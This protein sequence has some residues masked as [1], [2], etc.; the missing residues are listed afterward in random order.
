MQINVVLVKDKLGKI[1]NKSV[2]HVGQDASS[3]IQICGRDCVY[4]LEWKPTGNN[5]Y[6]FLVCKK[7]SDIVNLHKRARERDDGILSVCLERDAPKIPLLF[8]SGKKCKGGFEGVQGFVFCRVDYDPSFGGKLDE[9]GQA[10]RVFAAEGLCKL[11]LHDIHQLSQ[12]LFFDKT[13]CQVSL[14]KK[15]KKRCP[16][17]FCGN[18]KIFVSFSVKISVG[19]VLD[20]AVLVQV[21]PESAKGVV[22]FSHEFFKPFGRQESQIVGAS[23]SSEFSAHG[24][25]HVDAVHVALANVMRVMWPFHA[26]LGRGTSFE[27]QSRRVG[28]KD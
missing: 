13:Q 10:G 20:F 17:F 15:I 25:S 5:F 19:Q 27:M 24:R 23:K 2:K 11:S 14:P 6:K 22:Q 21:N 12:N 28:S 4:E 26:D 18:D 1:L 9:L 7:W 3:G 16:I 8:F